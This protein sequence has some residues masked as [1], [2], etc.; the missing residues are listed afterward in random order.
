ME[1]LPGAALKWYPKQPR[2]LS[3]LCDG[4]CEGPTVALS[5]Q[6]ILTFMGVIPTKIWIFCAGW[7]GYHRDMSPKLIWLPNALLQNWQSPYRE[8]PCSLMLGQ[9]LQAVCAC[10]FWFLPSSLSTLSLCFPA[11]QPCRQVLL[12]SNSCVH[13]RFSS[14]TKVPLPMHAFCLSRAWYFHN[15][16]TVFSSDK[17]SVQTTPY[18]IF[19]F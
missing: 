9:L 10:L 16:N 6:V 2:A 12:A 7:F 5:W 19:I 8:S 17:P 15:S 3:N 14:M 18:F 1:T 11:Q 4:H 13:P